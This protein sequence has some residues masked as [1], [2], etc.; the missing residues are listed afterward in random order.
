MSVIRIEVLK[1]GGA[2]TREGSSISLGGPIAAASEPTVTSSQISEGSRP[3]I[4]LPS[5]IFAENAVVLIIAK[6]AAV[7]VKQATTQAAAAFVGAG[8]LAAAKT[9]V[10]KYIAS[11]ESWPFAAADGLAFNAILAA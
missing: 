9:D 7:Y 2:R 1:A 8:D 3:L 11:G 10:T 5:G 6:D 4:A